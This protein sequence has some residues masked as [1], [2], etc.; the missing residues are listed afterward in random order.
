MRLTAIHIPVHG[1]AGCEGYCN[2]DTWTLA[3]TIVHTWAKIYTNPRQPILSQHESSATHMDKFL[4]FTYRHT[5]PTPPHTLLGRG[6]CADGNKTRGPFTLY[7]FPIF[8]LVLL[9]NVFSLYLY[10]V[11]RKLSLILYFFVLIRD[12]IMERFNFIAFNSY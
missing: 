2:T 5:S 11:K 8:S 10:F 1:A 3:P 7:Y 12:N 9:S 6:L 4:I